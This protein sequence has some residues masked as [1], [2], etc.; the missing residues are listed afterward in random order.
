M[1]I[2]RPDRNRKGADPALDHK[3]LIFLLGAVLALVGMAS[4][5]RLIVYLAIVILVAGIILRVV[6]RPR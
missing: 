2:F 6:H 1:G 5:N 3:L 4:G